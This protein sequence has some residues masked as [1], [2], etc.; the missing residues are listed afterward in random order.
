MLALKK[1]LGQALNNRNNFLKLKR[2]RKK[3]I[4]SKIKNDR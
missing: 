2:H 3:F 4:T 1:N